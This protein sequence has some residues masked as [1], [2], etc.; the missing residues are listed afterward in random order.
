MTTENKKTRAI[1]IK[2]ETSKD[3]SCLCINCEHRYLGCPYYYTP[4]CGFYEPAEVEW[5]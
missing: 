4:E 3:A 1:G 2:Q 5:M